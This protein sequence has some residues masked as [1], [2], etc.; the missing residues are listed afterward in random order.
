[1]MFVDDGVDG[2][3]ASADVVK[4]LRERLEEHNESRKA[5]Q[6]EL[7]ST[8]NRL[9]SQVS[10]L[11]GK[12]SKEL[13]E[14]FAKEKNRLENAL[15]EIYKNKECSGKLSE[16]TRAAV[17]VLATKW[18]CVVKKVPSRSIKGSHKVVTKNETAENA[19][20]HNKQE[21]ALNALN[22]HLEDAEESRKEAQKEINEIC[23]KMWKQIDALEE[24]VNS[25]LEGKFTKE[26]E[27]LQSA[28]G[29]LSD[30]KGKPSPKAL[31][32]AKTKLL[33]KQTYRL[34][35]FCIYPEIADLTNACKLTADKV[36]ETRWLEHKKPT[37]LNV[38]KA[39]SFG[40][41]YLGFSILTKNEKA[42]LTES[43]LEGAVPYKALLL[44]KKDET[45]SREYAIRKEEDN[46]FFFTPEQLEAETKYAVKVA[47]GLEVGEKA[48]WSD[49]AE[50]STP[51]F[52]GC[53]AW[54]ECPDHVGNWSKY[55]VSK[56]NPRTV[57]CLS[58]YG[59]WCTITGNTP[60]PH[61]KVT[62]WSIKILRSKFNDGN[63]IYIGIAPSGI[64][65][66]EDGNHN[67]CGWYFNCYDSTLWSGPPHSYNDKAYGP[68]KEEERKYVHTGDS[69]SV[70][71][72]TTKGELSFVVDGV[73]LGVAYDGIPLDKP[74]VPCVI[75]G[76]EGDSVEL[77][78]SEAKKK[79]EKAKSHCVIS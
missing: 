21:E 31:Q 15:E 71:M 49:E 40:R 5:V 17:S 6:K 27:R 28:L 1:M 61:S 16:A 9:R 58:S 32:N 36:V 29:S 11:E 67:K 54:K 50:F 4:A 73:N 26:D 37:G 72:D 2:A 75:L 35:E 53:C 44:K 23:E 46:L 3:A 69:V 13:E 78:T 63:G 24:K 79:D 10:D 60:L 47:V 39:G 33:V 43:G 18:N 14:G 45:Y 57:I 68:R 7:A 62:S 55:T 59:S 70:V 64:D 8:C 20:T 19:P 30:I 34:K 65:Q 51:E 56:E 41:V 48:E 12:L 42:T 66:N 76:E 74:L 25:E 52:S 77:N 38:E 22:T